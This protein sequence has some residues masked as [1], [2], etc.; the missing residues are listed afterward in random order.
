MANISCSRRGPDK[1]DKSINF[2]GEKEEKEKEKRQRI[3]VTSTFL[4]LR[5]TNDDNRMIISDPGP[6]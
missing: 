4:Y 3:Q 6:I 5:K 1:T 2:I